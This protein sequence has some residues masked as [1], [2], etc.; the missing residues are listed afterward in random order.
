[1]L[2]DSVCNLKMEPKE[3]EVKQAPNAAKMERVVSVQWIIF[4][5]L[6]T[7]FYGYVALDY[8]SDPESCIAT[9]E[10]DMRVV[11]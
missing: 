7:M 9:N 2:D 1:M 4:G 3:E 6:C 5:L 8:D 10:Y 11:F